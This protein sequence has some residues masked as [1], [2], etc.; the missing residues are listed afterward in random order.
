MTDE[1]KPQL[2]LTKGSDEKTIRQFYE[3]LIG[4]ALTPEELQ[5]LREECQKA[6]LPETGNPR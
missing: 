4:R 1:A 3:R 6:G 2:I 5:E